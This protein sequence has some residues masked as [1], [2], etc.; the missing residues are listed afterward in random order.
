MNKII[1]TTALVLLVLMAGC[2]SPPKANSTGL[3]TLENEVETSESSVIENGKILC[4]FDTQEIEMT[5]SQFGTSVHKNWIIPVTITNNSSKDAKNVV[6]TLSPSGE[7]KIYAVLYE[8]GS[9]SAGKSI[10]KNLD[11]SVR[12]TFWVNPNT[13]L[14]TSTNGLAVDDS[15]AVEIQYDA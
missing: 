13:L 8:L 14:T 5:L 1:L 12:Y 4:S 15:C 6:L 11:Y 2:T 3:V 9:I 7:E 10:T